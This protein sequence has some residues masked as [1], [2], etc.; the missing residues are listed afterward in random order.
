MNTKSSNVYAPSIVRKDTS[1]SEFSLRR[2]L[3]K[4]NKIYIFIIYSQT[5][6]CTFKNFSDEMEIMIF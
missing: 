5:W 3:P 4:Y 2:F 1:L 6:S